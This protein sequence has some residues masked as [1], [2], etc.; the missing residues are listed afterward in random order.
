MDNLFKS[1]LN[2]QV[3]ASIWGIALDLCGGLINAKVIKLVASVKWLVEE[4]FSVIDQLL[5]LTIFAHFRQ[6]APL[7][8][9]FECDDLIL[10]AELC[11]SALQQICEF[12]QSAVTPQPDSELDD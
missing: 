4:Y 11:L 7:N 10:I 1:T 8:K 2:S 5:H 3:L 9:V 12:Q 6:F